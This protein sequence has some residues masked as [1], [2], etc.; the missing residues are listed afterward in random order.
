M[1]HIHIYYT[2]VYRIFIHIHRP[3]LFPS[4]S[5]VIVIIKVGLWS[6]F[7]SSMV[8]HSTKLLL[9]TLSACKT[10]GH[11]KKDKGI[12]QQHKQASKHHYFPKGN[13]LDKFCAQSWLVLIVLS[14]GLCVCI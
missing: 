4:L 1:T 5:F 11:R 12:E 9:F 13:F 14:L 3:C 2:P 10:M 7:R 8:Q 6:S